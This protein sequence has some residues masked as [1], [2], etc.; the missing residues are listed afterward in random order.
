ME[1]GSAASFTITFL[2]VGCPTV[3]S[4]GIPLVEGR[5]RRGLAAHLKLAVLGLW[6]LRGE[7]GKS[8]RCEA[9]VAG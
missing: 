3:A 8:R 7:C 9:K 2:R 6:V 5:A 4:Q 1:I